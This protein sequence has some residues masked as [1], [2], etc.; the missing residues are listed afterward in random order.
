MISI[1]HITPHLGGG[2][3]RVLLNHIAHVH[4]QGAEQHT[5][6]CLEHANFSSASRATSIGIRLIDRIAERIPELLHMMEQNDVV[7]IHWWNHPLLYA[8]LVNET[9]PPARLLIWSHVAGLF[10]TQNFTDALVAYPDRFVIATPHSLDAPAIF[11]L[12]Q[13][14]RSAR[15]RLVFTCA[16]IEHVAGV[17]PQP[18]DGFRVG[19][20]GTVDYCKMHPDFIKMSAEVKIP[21]ARFIVCGG[22]NE[23]AIRSDAV[24][25]GVEDRFEFLG[26]VDDVA[27]MLA[28]FNVFGYPLA[29]DHYGTGEQ[30]LIE[31]LAVGIPPVVLANGAEQ[32][33]VQ[34]GITGIVARDAKEYVNALERLY[35]EPELRIKLGKNARHAARERFTIE[36]LANAWS[37]LYAE[38]IQ[39]PRQSRK[40][41]E[42]SYVSSGAELF[43]T[44][45]GEHGADYLESKYSHLEDIRTLAEERIAHKEGLFRARTRGTVFHYQTFYP[46]DPY[47]NLWCGLMLVVD[48]AHDEAQEYLIRAGR[49][50]E[51][52]SNKRVFI[53]QVPCD[54]S[55]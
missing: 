1:L 47:L 48:G 54:T 34:D 16:G 20:V 31:A 29:P 39:L 4:P 44:S 46:D 23:S 14:E 35:R 53:P 24:R 13:E 18:H 49:G 2:V 15:I 51:N 9:L 10:P 55:I 42:D 26:H 6:A 33:I 22:P 27:A 37:E 36:C 19:Y 17:K 8:L 11:R 43:I 41:K 3:G 21:E 5:I 45:L 38:V 7:V 52:K 28:S 25:I 32:H 50:I 12:T 40:W 30:A